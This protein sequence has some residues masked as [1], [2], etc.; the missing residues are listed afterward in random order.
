MDYKNTIETPKEVG[1]LLQ[2]RYVIVVSVMFFCGYGPVYGTFQHP[3]K[4][5]DSVLSLSS[6]RDDGSIRGGGDLQRT[7]MNAFKWYITV[8]QDLSCFE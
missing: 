4:L 8:H 5:W 6:I 1:T 3:F 2:Q 7:K